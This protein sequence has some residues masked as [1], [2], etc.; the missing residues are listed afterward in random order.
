MTLRMRRLGPVIALALGATLLAPAPVGAIA[1]NSPK[2]GIICTPGTVVGL[3]HT[4]HLVA[5]TGDIQTPDGNAVFMWSYGNG[6]APDNGAFQ[7]P[8]P[9]L[10]VTQGETVTVVLTNNLTEPSSIVFPG[11]DGSAGQPGVTASG[12]T[13]GVLTSEAAAGGGSVSYTFVAGNPGTYLYESG[14]DITKQVEMGLYGALIVRPSVGAAFAYGSATGF[15]PQREYLQLLSDFDPALHHAVE[16]GGAYDFNALHNRY[17][18][19]NGRMFPDTLQD[20]GSALLPTQ[21]YGALVRIQPTATSDAPALVRMVNAGVANHPYHPHGNHMTQ[22]A[23][24][25]RQLLSPGGS[26]ASSERFGETIGSGQ[27]QDYLLRWDDTDQWDPAN[28]PLPVAQPN[29]LNLTFKDGNTWYSGSPYLGYKGTLPV[30][31]NSLNICGEWYFPWHSHALNEFVNFNEPFGGMATLLRVDPPGGCS[32]SPTSTRITAGSLSGGSV[33]ALAAD[34]GTYYR[35]NSTTTGTRTTDWYVQFSGIPNAASNLRVSY[36][37]NDTFVPTTQNF[38]T[39]STGTSATL[40]AGWALSESGGGANTT[41]TG[42]NGGSATGNTYSYGTNGSSER[43]LGTLRGTGSVVSTIGAQFTNNTGAAITSLTIGYTGELWRYGAGSGVP[44]RLDFQY[45]TN[46]TSLTNGTWTDVNGLDF[47]SPGTGAAGSRNGNLSANRAAVSGAITGLNIP[48][49]ATYR[50]RWTDFDRTGN[51]DG[52]A[53]DDFS[54]TPAG[55]TF[56]TTLSI[57]NWAGAGSWVPFA[58][59]TAVGATD[60]AVATGAAVPTYI[61]TGS[62]RGLVRIRVLSTEGA[63]GTASFVTGG[64]LLKLTYDAP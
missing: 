13:A 19:V 42:N 23:Q 18:A 20:N 53:V 3:A 8:G 1:P 32:A 60:V 26:A 6:D 59:P 55:P 34:D 58:G 17:Y 38:D 41:Y 45:S 21:P 7:Y 24:D 57:W 49:G 46:A 50:V 10:C 16:T 28:N 22:I 4:F 9:V 15:N 36:T 11:Q 35:V 5:N 39:L 56:A 64:D 33:T 48:A 37:G 12:G 43:A 63:A 14:S 25:G 30:G 61:G 27:T 2:T 52:L 62:N 40:P 31:T 51:D 44:D 54:L 29:Y 47:N